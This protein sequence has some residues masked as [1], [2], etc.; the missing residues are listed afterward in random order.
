MRTT[1]TIDDDVA[2][3][4]QQKASQRGLSFKEVVNSLLRAGISASE[5]PVLVRPMIKIV[6]KPLGLKVGF[7]SD[8][9]GQLVDELEVES[10]LE[11]HR[12]L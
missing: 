12:Q 5:G 3:I 2:G 11:K 8:K 6:G 9:L 10:F 7:D 1:L 4:L